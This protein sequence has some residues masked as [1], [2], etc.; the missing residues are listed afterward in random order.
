MPSDIASRAWNEQQLIPGVLAISVPWPLRTVSDERIPKGTVIAQ[1][2]DF[3]S[4]IAVTVLNGDADARL[5]AM[6]DGGLRGM[7]HAPAIQLKDSR[8]DPDTLFGRPAL[9][10]AVHF[11]KK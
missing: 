1:G 4:T 5:D 8:K 10:L 3:G 9:R 2:E 11:Q 7:T 6:V